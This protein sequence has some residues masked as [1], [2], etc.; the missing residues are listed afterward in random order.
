MVAG[1]KTYG[2]SMVNMCRAVLHSNCGVREKHGVI[3]RKMDGKH[4]GSAWKKIVTWVLNFNSFFF[5]FTHSYLHVFNININ[6]S[7]N[8][9]LAYHHL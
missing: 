7:L 4:E 8:H 6:N 3:M 5:L 1:R 9:Y 2:N